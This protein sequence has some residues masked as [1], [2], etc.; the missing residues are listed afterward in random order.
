MDVLIG[1][2]L[3]L[4]VIFVIALLF[5]GGG[6]LGWVLE[7]IAQALGLLMEGWGKLFSNVL[8]CL[9]WIFIAILCLLAFSS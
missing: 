9:F 6:L 2:F 3:I 7:V 5:T 1:I 4:F 8:G